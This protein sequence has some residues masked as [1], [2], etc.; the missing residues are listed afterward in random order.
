MLRLIGT[1]IES[2]IS[3]IITAF[4]VANAI[5]ASLAYLL[6]TI[7][8]SS[9]SGIKLFGKFLT[10]VYDDF[11]EFVSDMNNDVFEIVKI[12][13]NR[14]INIFSDAITVVQYVT[15]FIVNS[16]DWSRLAT[17]NL[18]CHSCDSIAWLVYG[19]RNVCILIG[20]SIWLLIMIVPN[21]LLF[22]SSKT[23]FICKFTIDAF[24]ASIVA[25]IHAIPSTVI[26]TWNYFADF[27]L[28]S[29]CGLIVL[30]P[31]LKNHRIVLALLTLASNRCIQWATIF[32]LQLDRGTQ[33]IFNVC[34]CIVDW[35]TDALRLHRRRQHESISNDENISEIFDECANIC[36]NETSNRCVICQDRAKTVLLLPCRHLC[37]CRSCANHLS[38][39]YRS[40][41]PLCRKR[42]RDAIQVYVWS[43]E[44][45]VMKTKTTNNS[46][47]REDCQWET[48]E[49]LSNKQFELY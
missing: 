33:S 18:F 13:H 26:G 17:L 46:E 19:I 1:T 31:L 45:Q 48:D 5:G 38:E 4:S 49:E 29:F 28:Q 30:L 20:N 39:Q 15:D 14:L 44:R 16:F 10:I 23:L 37:L 36:G 40:I 2:T 27:P 35:I 24:I 32:L 12:F 25:I 47:Q 22:I 3:A 6:Q 7:A 21:S 11:C 43:E 34:Q 9:I 42:F 41:C 8:L